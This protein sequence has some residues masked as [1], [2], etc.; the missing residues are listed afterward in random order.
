MDT[1]T[2]RLLK[3]TYYGKDA[4]TQWD[5][6]LGSS[7][8]E[9]PSN[10]SQE[11]WSSLCEGPLAPN[12]FEAIGHD[13]ILLRM[14]IAQAHVTWREAL[15]GFLL[16]CSGTW[17]RGRQTPISLAY[18]AHLKPHAFAGRDEKPVS[19]TMCATCGLPLVSTLDRTQ[20]IFRLYWG[21]AW[22]ESPESYLVDLEE[23]AEAE[24]PDV[25]DDDRQTFR[26]LLE[27]IDEAPAEETPG[28]LQARLGSA[29]LLPGTDKYR[30]YGV[31]LALGEL[32]IMPSAVLGP[33][34]DGFIPWE[35]R[36]HASSKAGGSP[37]S[38]VV[39]PLSGWR[40]ELGIDWARVD[41]LYPTLRT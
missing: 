1:R 2:F 22:N 33:S 4:Q 34:A 20:D 39:V 5:E 8:Y 23:R 18:G 26:A 37:R 36:L 16:G 21:Y 24:M 29:K 9:R 40:G 15:D 7:R 32:G 35:V 11:D 13:E 19:N 25:E 41:T 3:Q 14:G 17:P 38:D 28:K 6:A 31:L 30:R 12:A 27:A 10:M